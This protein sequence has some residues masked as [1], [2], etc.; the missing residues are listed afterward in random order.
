MQPAPEGL[1]P[2]LPTTFN[3]S[4]VANTTMHNKR[5]TMFDT[6]SVQQLFDDFHLN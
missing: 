4:N 3:L 5:I 6:Q 2:G 1:W